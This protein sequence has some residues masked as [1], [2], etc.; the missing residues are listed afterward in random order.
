M[1]FSWWLR[2]KGS[3][4]GLR[5]L[6]DERGHRSDSYFADA[7]LTFARPDRILPELYA[8]IR[9]VELVLHNAVV[10]GLK[11]AFGDSD[12]A[13]WWH[14]GVPPEIQDAARKRA[15]ANPPVDLSEYLDLPNLRTLALDNWEAM[16]DLPFGELSK[17]K[18]KRGAE[19]FIALRNSVM[20]PQRMR[21]PSDADFRLAQSWRQEAVR[22]KGTL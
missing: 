4:S 21:M 1:F 18:W 6:L 2:G 8:D 5:E 7:L 3:S 12:D 10:E 22:L 17:S 14:R 20:H 16:E 11:A 19:R 9:V 13:D 15:P